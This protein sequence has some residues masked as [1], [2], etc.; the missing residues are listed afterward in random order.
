MPL[1][2]LP[3]MSIVLPTAFFSYR[4]EQVGQQNSENL[5]PEEPRPRAGFPN[6]KQLGQSLNFDKDDG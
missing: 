1:K 4:I 3:I 5:E 6:R 2:P